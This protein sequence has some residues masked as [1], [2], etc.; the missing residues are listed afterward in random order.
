VTQLVAAHLD[1]LA[2][3]KIVPAFPR[4]SGT[5]GAGKMGGGA[6]AI[7]RALEGD[8]FLKALKGVYDDHTGSMH[9]LTAVLRYMVGWQLLIAEF[10]AKLPGQ[11]LYT[12]GRRAADLRRWTHSLSPTY[13]TGTEIPNTHA[14][15]R[16]SAISSPARA[17]RRDHQSINSARKRRYLDAPHRFGARWKGRLPHRLRARVFEA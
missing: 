16:D 5:H 12:L 4:S 14:S 1:H 13:R 10:K 6:E 15:Y 17:R 11:G 8:M 9:K 2:E 7:E 3:Q